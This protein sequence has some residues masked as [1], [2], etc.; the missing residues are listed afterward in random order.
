MRRNVAGCRLRKSFYTLPIALHLVLAA[1]HARAD[2]KVPV[3]TAGALA[4]LKSIPQPPL[5][6]DNTTQLCSSDKPLGADGPECKSATKAYEKTL[7]GLLTAQWWNAPAPALEAC[8]V[9]GKA[10]PL[11]KHETESLAEG[12]GQ[13]VQGTGRVRMLVVGDACGAAGMSNE[14]LV[15]R[16]GEGLALTPLYY[17]FNQGGQEA[18]FALDVAINNSDT[19]A[20]FTT[21]GHD[22]QSIY[23]STTAYKVD[24]KTGYAMEYPLFFSTAGPSTRV[25][26]SS[27]VTG[28]FK[29][30]DTAM[31]RNGRFVKRFNNY[32]DNLCKEG[33]SNC[34]PVAGES[35]TWNGS[36]FVVSDYEARHTDF[37]RKLAIQRECVRKKFDPKKGT[38]DCGAP[39]ECENYND[40]AWLNLKSGN[41]VNARNDAEM[42]LDFCRANPREYKA[43]Q[44]NYRQSQHGLG[45]KSSGE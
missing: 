32:R 5:A 24:A 36:A 31:V 17:D 28:D 34:Q 8:R 1:A 22:M 19:F 2:Q 25:D 29:L 13:Q 15:V 6:C 3:C 38:A 45:V 33:D 37:L 23:T 43:A 10:G 39:A 20:L 12:Y 35:Y 30:T 9:H 26:Q 18:P 11:T 21:E 4:A 44:Y 41:F 16:T 40:L 7:A 27:P 14:F 42:A